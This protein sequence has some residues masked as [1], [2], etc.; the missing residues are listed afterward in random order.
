MKPNYRKGKYLA[1]ID[2]GYDIDILLSDN[3]TSLTNKG[4]E[5]YMPLYKVKDGKIVRI[6]KQGRET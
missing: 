6:N 1:V 2:R 5:D 4:R 3:L